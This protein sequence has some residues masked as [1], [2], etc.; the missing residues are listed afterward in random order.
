MAG[1]LVGVG[2]FSGVALGLGVVVEVFTTIG[3]GVGVSTT[4]VQDE[5]NKITQ[6]ESIS[7]FSL[8]FIFHH[9]QPS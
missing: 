1:M 2:V 7:D 4:D 9:Q 3:A 5:S 6:S 8:N